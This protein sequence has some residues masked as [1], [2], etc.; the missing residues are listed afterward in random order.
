M[1]SCRTDWSI[2]PNRLSL[3][4]E[5]RRRQGLPILDLTESNPTRCGFH[6]DTQEIL[7]ALADP[8]GL[9]YEPDPRGLLLARQ[10]VAG[11][12]A[13]RGIRLEPEQIILTTGTSEAYSYSFRLLADPGDNVLV[14]RPSYPLFDFLGR[15]D[16]LELV[17]YRLTYSDGWQ[18]DLPSVTGAVTP[19]T[20]AI[21]VVHPNN[22]TGSFARP[23]EF[24]FLVELC[25]ARGLALVCDEVF[26]D[27]GFVPEGA[28]AGGGR[29]LL[30]QAAAREVLTFTLS[31]LSK[32]S[33]LPQMKLAWIVVSGPA[34]L[35]GS[36]LARL[37]LIA[38]TY[39]SVSGPLAGALP[40][41]LEVRR[42]LQPQILE[43]LRSNLRWLDQ[44]LSPESPV[45]RLRAEGGWYA[46][47]KVPSNR[48]DED[49]AIEILS[50]DGV[51][52][53][54]GHFYDFASEGHL[55]ASLL[56]PPEV[57]E[58]GMARV[59]ARVGRDG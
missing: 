30:R 29:H 17:P 38:D 40:V 43:R 16:G 5:K 28:A 57:F 46:T 47:L 20:R 15:L 3:E 1:F 31:G 13:E 56:P 10:A 48:S 58:P 49:W 6:Y 51:L 53:H 42:R 19:R 54:P 52:A 14:P 9:T 26:A 8:G 50:R 11:Y 59:L 55:V 4:L 45:S 32:I 12:Y 22:P 39:L 35:L 34:N 7:G 24:R 18:I 37:E 44:H 21:L 41:L 23:E 33:A 27:Y 2:T 36:A 25:E